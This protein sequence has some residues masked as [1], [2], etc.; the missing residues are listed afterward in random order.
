MHLH[1]IIAEQPQARDLSACLSELIGRA[2]Q[3]LDVYE[4]G[5]PL[6]KPAYVV[7]ISGHRFRAY[8]QDHGLTH[9]DARYVHDAVMLRGL[10]RGT[11]VVLVDGWRQRQDWAAIEDLLGRHCVGRDG[12]ALEYF[13]AVERAV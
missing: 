4:A 5:R 9:L 3:Y 1:P 2:T 10:A 6:P 8:L 13:Y 12:G 11:R 7:A